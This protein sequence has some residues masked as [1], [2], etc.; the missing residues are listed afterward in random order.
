MAATG[1]DSHSLHCQ[2][3]LYLTTQLA[4]RFVTSHLFV[5]LQHQLSLFQ[6]Q[7]SLH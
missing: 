5:S 4:I 3:S 1:S 7:L 2:L 6:Y